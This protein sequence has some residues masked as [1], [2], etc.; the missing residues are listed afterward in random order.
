MTLPGRLKPRGGF[1]LIELMV[2][3]LILGLLTFLIVPQYMRTIE[4]SKADDAAGIVKMIGTAN[5]M[6][7]VDR[8]QYASGSLDD[9][10]SG[11]C[12]NVSTNSCQL[13]YCKYLAAMD[14]K[15]KAYVFQACDKTNCCSIGSVAPGTAAPNIIA[16]AKRRPGAS[17]GTTKSNYMQ[18]GYTTNQDG[19][20]GYY[21]GA[22]PAPTPP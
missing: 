12:D 7:Y 18:W 10:T 8:N 17:P 11:T 16:C 14:W 13:I 20:T 4:S 22:S 2:V 3:V 9:C 5:R 15:S 6:F 21:K 1:T 19:V